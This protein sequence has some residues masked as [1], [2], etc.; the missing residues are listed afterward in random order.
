MHYKIDWLP[1]S[2]DSP[3]SHESFKLRSD[4]RTEAIVWVRIRAAVVY[5]PFPS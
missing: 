1:Q 3:L 4:T 2:I 5:D